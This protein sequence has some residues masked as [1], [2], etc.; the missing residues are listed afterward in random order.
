MSEIK[1][2]DDLNIRDLPREERRAR[3]I[4]IRERG[5]ISSRLDVKLPP[6][7]HGEWFHNSP[8]DIARAQ[9]LGFEIDTKYAPSQALHSDG[10][11]RAIVGDVIFMTCPKEVKEDIDWAERER[12]RQLRNPTRPQPEESNAATAIAALGLEPT[13]AS[14][15]RLVGQEEIKSTV[16]QT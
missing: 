12:L 3:L 4:R 14:T 10:T 7:L 13:N 1:E 11:G 5:Y 9:S 15:R 2:T 8:V 6:E 16:E